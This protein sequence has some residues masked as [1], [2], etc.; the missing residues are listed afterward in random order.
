VQDVAQEAR[1]ALHIEGISLNEKMYAVLRLVKW[2]ML[3]IFL[4][5]GFIG[6]NF[7]D[8]CPAAAI[9]PALAGF[10]LSLGLGGFF[11]I[12]VIVAGFFKRRAF[13]NICP[14]GYI[15]GLTHKASLFKLKK[16]AVA[17]TECG[18]CYEACPMGIKSIFTEREGKDIRKIDVTTADC[19][20]CGKC[21]HRCP[22]NNALAITFCG[23]KIYNADR[24]KFM[25]QYAPKPDKYAPFYDNE[26]HR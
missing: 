25:K 6:G 12:V 14:L 3:I 4:G 21:V 13:C 24:I 10:K 15:L 11:M 19:I 23:K 2:I 9:S 26:K 7:C 16:D 8:F 5:I 22:E 18:A 17:C 1:Q 20:M